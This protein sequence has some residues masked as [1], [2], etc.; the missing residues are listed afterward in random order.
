M[1]TEPDVVEALVAL[2]FSLNEG[3]AY[4]A[5]L[6]HGPQTG[7]EV[8]Q[9]AQVPRSAVYG[10]L[11]RL[12]SVGAAR[13]IAGTPERFVAAPPDTL[14]AL[15]KKRFDGQTVSLEKAIE[16]MDVTPEVPDAFSVRGYERVLEEAERVVSSA[17]EKVLVAGWNRELEVLGDALRQAAKKSIDVTLF[18]HSAL[19]PELPG[20]RFSY[21]LAE[22]DL[23][24][25][26]KH[27]LVVVADD[28]RT[29]VGATEQGPGD[30]AV[31]SETSA[32]AELATSQITLDITLLAQRHKWDT[33]ATM[34]RLL[35]DRVGRLDSLLGADAK[36]ELGR[37][38]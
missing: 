33:G 22:S 20:M 25:F 17:K 29:L 8:G 11:R 21:G 31:I 15:L 27:R 32:I 18:S 16:V 35:G 13:S 30:N 1:A 3:R 7:Y 9:R 36:A 37:R 12:V 14:I 26:W 23:E 5:L 34:A 10:A 2:G 24:S 38:V 28:R 4:A 6:A 19:S